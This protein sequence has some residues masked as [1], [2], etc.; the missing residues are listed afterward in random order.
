VYIRFESNNLIL[1]VINDG[2]Y[3]EKQNF[4]IGIKNTKRRLEIIYGKA[5]GFEIKNIQNKVHTHIWINKVQLI[6]TKHE[7]NNH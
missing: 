7:S 4:G 2:N 5:A 3:N 6:E 1:E